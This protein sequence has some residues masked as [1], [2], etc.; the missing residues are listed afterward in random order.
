M[1][2]KNM[3]KRPSTYPL[4]LH[5]RSAGSFV[6]N[7]TLTIGTCVLSSRIE[8]PVGKFPPWPTITT[9][10]TRAEVVFLRS[11][12]NCVS[13][14]IK[15][16]VIMQSKNAR[17]FS[18]DEDEGFES[19]GERRYDKSVSHSTAS[20]SRTGKDDGWNTRGL[21]KGRSRS[22]VRCLRRNSRTLVRESRENS[23]KGTL[24]LGK[25]EKE[26]LPFGPNNRI[27]L[28]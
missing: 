17:V 23:A 4:P 28:G 27:S 14:S 12:A 10:Y 7:R 9:R 16:L 2:G 25:Q 8:V 11:A 15:S 19:K 26:K 1:Y 24:E 3:E 13:C 22:D 6:P 21:R 5:V 20:V 18:E